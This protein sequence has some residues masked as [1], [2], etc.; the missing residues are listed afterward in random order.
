MSIGFTRVQKA[1]KFVN[2]G[3][4][5]Q[6]APTEAD[7]DGW[8]KQKRAGALISGARVFV[9][10]ADEGLEMEGFEPPTCHLKGDNPFH[11][12]PQKVSH[13]RVF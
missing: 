6:V 5:C 3:A 4:T 8:R 9:K 2:V 12:D 10:G 7:D 11:I 1:G 13:V